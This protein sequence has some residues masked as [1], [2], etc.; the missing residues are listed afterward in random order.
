MGCNYYPFNEEVVEQVTS[1]YDVGNRLVKMSDVEFEY[2]GSSNQLGMVDGPYMYVRND[3]VNHE[4]LVR[5]RGG[6]PGGFPVNLRDPTG[7]V[8]ALFT[9]EGVGCDDI[10]IG[11]TEDAAEYARD[12]CEHLKTD[13]DPPLW[14]KVTSW[15]VHL[16]LKAGTAVI[17]NSEYRECYKNKFRESLAPPPDAN[18]LYNVMARTHSG[19]VN[20]AMVHLWGFH[21]MI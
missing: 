5:V 4:N 17:Q 6:K 20:P 16:A 8:Y 7:K 19:S 21:Y 2:N 3:P 18:L 11:R 13:Y 12:E 10:W 1:E 15:G 9:N 14:F